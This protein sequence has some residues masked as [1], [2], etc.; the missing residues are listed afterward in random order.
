MNKIESGDAVTVI[1][2]NPREKIFGTLH[3][4]N[5]AGVF[6][7]GIDLEYFEEW[8]R[9]IANDEPFLPLNDVFVPMWRI[10]KITLDESSDLL[11]SLTERFY[12]QT[13]LNFSDF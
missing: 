5:A 10:E 6:V 2:Q 11:P 1:L 13:N 7:R 4:I 9:E 8:T 12:S 3:E